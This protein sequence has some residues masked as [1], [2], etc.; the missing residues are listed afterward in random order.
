MCCSSSV[1]NN[2]QSLT[3]SLMSIKS[4][5]E[6]SHL[7][8]CAYV[9][10]HFRCSLG[11]FGP[12]SNNT[13]QSDLLM[14]VNV[15]QRV[16]SVFTRFDFLW[17]ILRALPAFLPIRVYETIKS[18]NKHSLS[19]AYVLLCKTASQ[20]FDQAFL[21]CRMSMFISV[22]PFSTR[23]H[24]NVVWYNN[25]WLGFLKIVNY[26]PKEREKYSSKNEPSFVT[27]KCCNGS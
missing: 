13:Y 9:L 7:F 18:L 8:S 15:T 14:F 24:Q 1:S 5:N 4:L 23:P 2:S 27:V 10:Y 11:D 20:H 17:S 25:S 12:P 16:D 22:H 21:W 6:L 3:P 26:V 19:W